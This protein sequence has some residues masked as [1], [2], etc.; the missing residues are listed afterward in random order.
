[1]RKI[2]ILLTLFCGLT[3]CQS[4]AP[5]ASIPVPAPMPPVASMPAD[6]V[7]AQDGSGNFKTVQ[8]A[9]QSIPAT[10]SERIV[11]LIK[12]GIYKEK[13]RIDASYVTLRGQSR[14]G[15][16]IEYPQL[17]DDFTKNPDDIGR[18]VVNVNGSDVVL[19]NL[20]IYN[21]A[22]K[23]GPHAF[24]VYGTGD[25][26]III[27]SNVLS[28]GADT[29]SL[30]HPNG[31]R[32]YHARC[33]FQGSVDFVCPR[34]WCYVTDCHFKEVKATASVW[35]DGHADKDQKYVLHNCR[36]DGVQG[37]Y[38]ARHH[39]DAQFYFLDCSFAKT[40]IDKPPRRVIY[41][42][43]GDK[44]TTQD[45]VRNTTYNKTNI[46]GEREYYYNCHRDGG[47]YTWFADNLSSAPGSPTPNE[48]T[49]AWTFAGT[50]DPQ[51]TRG[52][53]VI[54]V[55]TSAIHIAV[56]FSQSVTV[57]G[58]KPVLHLADG[59]IAIYMSGSGTSTLL[60]SV[61]GSS[62]A[63]AKYLDPSGGWI[64]ATQATETILPADLQLP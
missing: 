31:G 5:S 39:Q 34:G 63:A 26:T 7:V 32:S 30:W 11:I 56:T 19:E 1:M 2:W 38:L 43:P 12:D 29:V 23:I 24:A 25:K 41:P 54:N 28:E 36:F 46:W 51:S 22:G 15:T 35:H 3:A 52:P 27:D 44:P 9:V 58:N 6:I 53:T 47:D 40:M 21:T 16:R 8:Q 60:F 37:F 18:A 50:W 62:T 42:L 33:N 10:N 61:V 57:R 20:T 55:T 48:I 64:V 14:E 4:T 45:S 13:V 59:S 49:A 17:N